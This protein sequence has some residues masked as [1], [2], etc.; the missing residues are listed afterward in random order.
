MNLGLVERDAG[1]IASAEVAFTEAIDIWERTG[2]RQR[3]SV[4]VHNAALLDLDRGR[5]DEAAAMLSRAYDIARDLGDR[6][7]MAYALADTA[8]VEVERGN[9][10]AAAAALA[11]SLRDP[12]PPACGSSSRC[13]WRRR[14]RL[15]AARGED[16]LA[17]RLWSSA[18]AERTSSGFVNMPADERL[19]DERIARHAWTVRSSRVRAAPGRPGP[20]SG[21]RARSISHVGC[22][23]RRTGGV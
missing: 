15:A 13:C 18:T 21:T 1:R 2:D 7:E 17:V 10:E 20:P 22:R 6:T 4:G 16:E 9:L 12:S 23:G 14:A 5:Y 8:R 19:L 3:V 11:W